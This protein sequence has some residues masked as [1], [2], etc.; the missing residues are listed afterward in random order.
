MQTQSANKKKQATA[1]RRRDPYEE[2]FS[3]TCQC[4]KLNSMYMDDIIDMDTSG[5]Y[6]QV[7]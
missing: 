2:F 5:Y 7:R 4:V 1:G 6:I 3:L